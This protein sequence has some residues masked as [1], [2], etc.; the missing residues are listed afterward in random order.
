MFISIL[1]WVECEVMLISFFIKLYI[2]SSKI[3]QKDFPFPFKLPLGEINWSRKYGSIYGLCSVLLIFVYLPIN[4]AVLSTAALKLDKASN[5]TILGSLISLT[6][7][8]YFLICT[9][10]KTLGILVDIAF[11]LFLNW[12]RIHTLTLNFQFM[13]TEWHKQ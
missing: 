13:N 3:C 8:G 12:R 5:L 11:N 4:L 7:F 10:K 2:N 9:F 6:N 1:F